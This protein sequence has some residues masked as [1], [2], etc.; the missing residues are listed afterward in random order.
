MPILAQTEFGGGA[1]KVWMLFV[2]PL[3]AGGAGAAIRP[4]EDR[5][6]G[7][8]AAPPAVL[9]MIA[10]GLVAGGIAGVLQAN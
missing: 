1:A 4:M 9:A 2:V 8:H 7:M 5:Q 3:V 6:R 10:L